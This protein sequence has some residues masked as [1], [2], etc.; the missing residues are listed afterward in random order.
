MVERKN[1]SFAVNISDKN[2]KNALNPYPGNMEN[3]VS[4]Q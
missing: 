3:M 2:Q 1:N 4:S